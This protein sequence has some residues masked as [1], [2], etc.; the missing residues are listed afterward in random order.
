MSLLL[1]SEIKGGFVKNYVYLYLIDSDLLEPISPPFFY[2]LFA[3]LL[4]FTASVIYLLLRVM[5][6][7]YYFLASIYLS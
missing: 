4:L 6:A 5:A 7:T 3:S 2:I 1:I